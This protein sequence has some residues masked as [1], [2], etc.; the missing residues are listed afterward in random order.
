ASCVTAVRPWTEQE[1]RPPAM[2]NPIAREIRRL[3]Q[4]AIAT[5]GTEWEFRSRYVE[6]AEYEGLAQVTRRHAKAVIPDDTQLGI[7][8]TIELTQD[9]VQLMR[10]GQHVQAASQS[11]DR[12]RD[13][14]CQ[15]LDAV[16]RPGRKHSNRGL[17]AVAHG[18]KAKSG[19][20]GFGS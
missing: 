7:A 12:R 17:E 1:R 19:Q 13:A 9:I 3:R 11:R 16:R 20:D 10:G 4:E 18:G 6:E 5:A 14:E 2:K 15:S 8:T